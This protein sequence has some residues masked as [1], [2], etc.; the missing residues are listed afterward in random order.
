MCAFA[1][2]SGAPRL[3]S[4]GE[5]LEKT[6]EITIQALRDQLAGDREPDN[7]S[8]RIDWEKQ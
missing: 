4:V 2:K 1:R 8:H 7:T 6:N 5:A 3:H